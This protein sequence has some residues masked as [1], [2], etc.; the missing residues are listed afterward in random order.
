VIKTDAGSGALEQMVRGEYCPAH[1]PALNRGLRAKLATLMEALAEQFG[2]AAELAE[3][4]G[5]MTRP[6]ALD[7]AAG[8]LRKLTNRLW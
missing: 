1:V 4:P 2:T 8:S 6:R 5:G 3:P 7:R